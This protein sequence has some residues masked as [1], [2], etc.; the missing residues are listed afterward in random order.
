VCPEN[1]YLHGLVIV[2]HQLEPAVDEALAAGE[3]VG[4]RSGESYASRN[5]TEGF[6]YGAGSRG[7]GMHVQR[8]ISVY[9]WL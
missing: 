8:A 5:T 2:Y 7:I 9:M 3:V 6:K 4:G 1:Q